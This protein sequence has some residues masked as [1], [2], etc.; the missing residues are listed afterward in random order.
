MGSEKHSAM[1]KI[2]HRSSSPLVRV[3]VPTPRLRSMEQQDSIG[4]YN[5]K[6]KGFILEVRASRLF[7]LDPLAI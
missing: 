1:H 6:S 3:G 5:R 7:P 2:E 4:K